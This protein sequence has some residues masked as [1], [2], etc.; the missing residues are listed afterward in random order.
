MQDHARAGGTTGRKPGPPGH[1]DADAA[2]G[3]ERS[4]IERELRRRIEADGFPGGRLP[5][6]RVLAEEL[7]VGR[8]ALREALSVLEGEGR[9][10]RRQGLGTFA[11]APPAPVEPQMPR[12]D[13]LGRLASPVA[14]MEARLAV[15]P[16]AARLAAMRA[17]QPQLDQL[18]R[19]A[20]RTFGARSAQDYEDLDSHFH[21][22]IAEVAGNVLLLSMLDLLSRVRREAR[23]GQMR[24]ASFSPG[25]LERLGA[26]H[27]AILEAITDR[28]PARAE[29]EMR[30]H[31]RAVAVRLVGMDPL[32]LLLPPEGGEG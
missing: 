6:E 1:G 10:W 32:P 14:V 31:L 18:A 15:E 7:G 12:A 24:A 9:I 3:T 30:R 19:A 26:E 16:V 17:T 21:R 2:S 28:D 25:R 5:P 13:A 23:W 20:G 8:R 27:T 11:G 29:A 4:G 22:T